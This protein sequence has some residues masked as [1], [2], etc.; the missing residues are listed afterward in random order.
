MSFDKFLWAGLIILLQFIGG[1]AEQNNIV[2]IQGFREN[3]LLLKMHISI[4]KSHIENANVFSITT[5][6]LLYMCA[7]IF[8]VKLISSSF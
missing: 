6:A 8:N 5:Q 1:N 3:F 2:N 7:Y 4:I